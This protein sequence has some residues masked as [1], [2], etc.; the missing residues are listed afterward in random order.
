M[1][2][3]FTIGVRHFPSPI[4]PQ[5]RVLTKDSLGHSGIKVVHALPSYKQAATTANMSAPPDVGV[6]AI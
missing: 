4:V 5:L 3:F 6:Q 2:Y 1:P